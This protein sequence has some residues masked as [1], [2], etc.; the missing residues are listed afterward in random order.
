MLPLVK[1]AQH[2][3][4]TMPTPARTYKN[5]GSN[6][7]LLTTMEIQYMFTKHWYIHSSLLLKVTLILPNTVYNP[8]YDNTKRDCY[9][10]KYTQ[11]R[12]HMYIH[13]K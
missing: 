4:V 11:H 2:G 13:V 9:L 1:Q 10:N 7:M 12:V 8:V 5:V 3:L 6:R